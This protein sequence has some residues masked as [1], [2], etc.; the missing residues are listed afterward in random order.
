MFVLQVAVMKGRGGMLS[1]VTHYARM[2][3]AIGV[4][5]ATLYRGPAPEIVRGVG[6]LID[7]PASLTSPLFGLSPDLTALRRSIIEAGG[8]APD[9]A[10]VHSD[11][12]LNGVK[13][14]FPR[15]RAAAVCH[16]DKMKRKGR[17]D[18]I[19]T[20]N[21]AQSAL[22]RARWPAVRVAQLGNPYVAPPAPVR[23]PGAR[24]RLNFVARFIPTKQPLSLI[25]ALSK[26]Q[27]PP[28]LRFIGAGELEAEMRA[29]VAESGLAAE[30]TGWLEAPFSHFHAQDILVL[31][32]LWEGLPYLLQEALDHGV[33]IL[34]GD[35]AG[36][37]AALLD[38]AYGALFAAGD[39]SALA[40]A[41]RDA[42]AELDALRA[43]AEN[44]R[45]ALRAKY[46]ATSFW[47]ALSAELEQVG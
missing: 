40:A 35:N 36:N 14:M 44:G 25:E 18:L 20:L 4:R 42:L 26:L 39:T 5:S 11:L 1:A 10:I 13:R 37:R 7:A 15:A 38:G 41:I 43:K 6:G 34:A 23:P 8:A 46:G 21:A 17:A 27:S 12:A 31:P 45:A 2:F 22:A 30:F 24:P 16:S 47:R 28:A 32:S 33:P 29:A 9:V 19:V 3:E